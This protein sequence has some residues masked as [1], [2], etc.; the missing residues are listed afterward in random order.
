MFTQ[1]LTSLVLQWPNYLTRKP[2]RPVLR[3]T[4]VQYLTAFCSQPKA[5]SDV[6][7]GRSVGPL[8]LDSRANFPDPHSNFS[9]DIPPEAV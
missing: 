8:V 6:I 4:Y 1:H 7:S 3:I 2:A 9:R 5:T